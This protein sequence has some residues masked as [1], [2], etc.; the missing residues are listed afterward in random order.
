[1]VALLSKSNPDKNLKIGT[2]K[3]RTKRQFKTV[4][5]IFFEFLIFRNF[6]N[7]NKI[8]INAILGPLYFYS[9]VIGQVPATKQA[10]IMNF[11]SMLRQIR[12]PY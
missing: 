12:R 6:R 5:N 11:E 9:I 2:V 3:T 8:D 1:M 4:Q 7:F 10:A